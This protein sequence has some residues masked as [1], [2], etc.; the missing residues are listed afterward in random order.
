MQVWAPSLLNGLAEWNFVDFVG[1]LSTEPGADLV[2]EKSWLFHNGRN[3]RHKAC[4]EVPIN[5]SVIE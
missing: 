5:D 1:E 3:V 2:Q 4:G